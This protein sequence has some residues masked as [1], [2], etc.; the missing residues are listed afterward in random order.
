MRDLRDSLAN[1]TAD[2]ASHLH[3]RQ[4][5]RRAVEDTA[6]DLE[7]RMDNF[8]QLAHTAPVRSAAR[9]ASMRV[10]RWLA[11]NVAAIVGVP[12]GTASNHTE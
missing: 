8:Q 10:D 4:G 11:Q 6:I 2:P 3:T 1:A 9:L 5:L 12:S 7:F